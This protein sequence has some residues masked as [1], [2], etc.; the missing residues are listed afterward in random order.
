MGSSARP[1][2]SPPT[3]LATAAPWRA[4]VA[5]SAIY[6]VWGSTYLAIRLVVETIPPFLSGA[7]RFLLA[8]ALLYAWVRV[9][10]GREPVTRRELAGTAVVGTLLVLGGNGLVTVA[11]REVPSGLA[12]LLIASVPLWVVLLRRISG[13]PLSRR[14]L[15]AVCA[16]FLG[17]GMLLAPGQRPAGVG[18]AGLLLCILAAACWASGS[19]AGARLAM[20]SDPLRSTALQMLIGGAVTAVAAVVAGDPGALRLAQ[21][22]TRSGLALVYLIFV[23][24]IVAFSAYAWL[25]RNVP[26]S[27]VSTYAYVNPVIAVALGWAILSEPVTAVTLAGATV[28]VGS[29]AFTVRGEG[30]AEPVEDSAGAAAESAAP[31]PPAAGMPAAEPS[32]ADA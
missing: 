2:S 11:E 6:L 3:P 10:R 15:V 18:L 19:F 32:R 1:S 12:A 8:G 23:G 16:G 31:V 13:E 5:L 17:V 9:V 25:L 20:P 22:S 24:S 28:I 29:V 14:T 30:I 26:L 27:T 4:A 21:V 7:V